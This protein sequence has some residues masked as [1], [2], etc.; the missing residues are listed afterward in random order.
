MTSAGAARSPHPG[1]AAGPSAGEIPTWAP[2]PGGVACPGDVGHFCRGDLGAH[3]RPAAVPLPATSGANGGAKPLRLAT[4]PVLAAT[5]R[6]PTHSSIFLPQRRPRGHEHPVPANAPPPPPGCSPHQ[7]RRSGGVAHAVAAPPALPAPVPLTGTAE[8]R[9]TVSPP[10][11][12][13]GADASRGSSRT[14][15]GN[16]RTT[17]RRGRVQHTAVPPPPPPPPPS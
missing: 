5:A 17:R 4:A 14:S 16:S 15:R 10:L 6:P 7:P 2:P 12:T 9:N 13:T 1:A 8:R 11:P 3:A